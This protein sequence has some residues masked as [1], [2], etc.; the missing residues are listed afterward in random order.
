MITINKASVKEA[1]PLTELSRNIYREHY[2]HLWH[3][4]GA[5]W[6][7]EK[8]AYSREKIERELGDTNVEYY[9]AVEN[10]VTAGYMK[11]VLLAPVPGNAMTAALEV[12]RIY[13]HT[14][15]MGKGIGKIL[16]ELALE[17]AR[18]LKRDIILLKAMDSATAAISFYSA[19]GYT[20]SGSLELPMPDFALMKKEYRGM[21][22]LKREVME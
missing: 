13:L 19:L 21:V 7:M 20:I 5:E 10:G 15:S 17:R 12:E 18:E 22:T 2:L 14:L 8:Y 6:Y 9:I 11:L 16:M 1:E 3:P 4:G